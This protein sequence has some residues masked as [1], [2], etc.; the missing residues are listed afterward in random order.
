[1]G[2]EAK[3]GLIRMAANYTRVF[4]TFAFGL[5]LVPILIRGLGRDGWALWVL[6]GSTAGLAQMV[7]TIVRA[8]MIRELGAAYHSGDDDHFR[9]IYNASILAS[10]AVAILTLLV[11]A[12]LWFILPILKIPDGLLNAARFVLVTGAIDAVV[13]IILAAPFNMYKVTER[14]VA[15]NAWTVALRTTPLLSAV[16]WFVIIGVDDP[17]AGIPRFAATSVALFVATL[18]IASAVMMVADRRLIPAPWTVTC[19]SL[20]SVIHVGGSNAIALTGTMLHERLGAII[21]NLA[22][23]LFGNLIFGLSARLTAAV[24]R[25]TIGVTEGLE[26]VSVRISTQK[27]DAALR[28]L[29][30]HSTRLQGLAAFPVAVVLLVLAGPLLTVWVQDSLTGSDQGKME[31]IAKTIVL[32]RIMTLGLAARAI[33]D[34]WLRILYGG[35]FV[36]RYALPIV[37]GAVANPLLAI[38]LL[39]AMPEPVEY[40]AVAYAYSAVLVLVHLIVM[41]VI[42]GRAIGATTLEV[43][44]PLGRPM[45]VALVCC[46]L[47]LIPLNRIDSESWDFWRLAIVATTYGIAVAVVGAFVVLKGDERQRFAKAVL[48]RL[49]RKRR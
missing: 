14:M 1:M 24:R 30:Y 27:G 45:I 10:V 18:S 47:L 32:I 9:S 25:L 8:S 29:M 5:I 3:R 21:M 48:S 2:S 20:R 22:F 13:V 16:I 46:P 38:G 40:T 26:A 23:G 36:R 33:C 31:T 28:R 42:A 39:Q 41:P 12:V 15:F 35:G 11:F 4:T 34:G 6:L 37:Y 19:A 44:S 43:L 7:R 17:V 49:P